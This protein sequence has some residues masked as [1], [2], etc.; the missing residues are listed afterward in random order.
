MFVCFFISQKIF[1]VFW[2][3]SFSISC[4]MSYSHGFFRR[5]LFL[6]SISSI[7]S[8]FILLFF[9]FSF[10]FLFLL[11]IRR[12]RQRQR[13]YFLLISFFYYYVAYLP[14]FMLFYFFFSSC[15]FLF[16][17]CIWYLSLLDSRVCSLNSL[18]R[19]YNNQTKVTFKT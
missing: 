1:C 18:C 10:V 4:V 17:T 8:S 7:L 19:I 14:F 12:Q 5:I 2:S 16:F 6:L 3:K 11:A 13:F 15:L 9:A